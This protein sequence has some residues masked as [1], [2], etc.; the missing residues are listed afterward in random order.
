[1]LT[2]LSLSHILQKR[3]IYWQFRTFHV[4][5]SKQKALC[6]FVPFH[7]TT[8]THRWTKPIGFSRFFGAIYRKRSMHSYDTQLNIANIKFLAA[9][10]TAWKR[11]LLL[12]ESNLSWTSGE[13]RSVWWWQGQGHFLEWEDRKDIELIDFVEIYC[14][15]AENW[16]NVES[17]TDIY[18]PRIPAKFRTEK[19]FRC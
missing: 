19:K 12:R 9:N 11:S 18:E 17:T 14:F 1:M 13:W 5:M 6:P 16:T 2:S 15:G 3:S 4:T 10:L 8:S 7:A